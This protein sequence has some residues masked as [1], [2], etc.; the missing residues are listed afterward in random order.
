MC[1]SAL[2][3]CKRLVG[4]DPGTLFIPLSVHMNSCN[5]ASVCNVRRVLFAQDLHAAVS[6]LQQENL[7]LQDKVTMD[8]KVIARLQAQA[9]AWVVCG[10]V[11]GS[12]VRFAVS[13]HR[14]KKHAGDGCCCRAAAATHSTRPVRVI[15]SHAPLATH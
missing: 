10:S 6:L 5:N 11:V 9:S 8:A 1:V 12:V 7:L 13:V 15:S 14:N 4:S 2:V 3:V